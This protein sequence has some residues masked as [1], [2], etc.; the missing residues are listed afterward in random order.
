VERTSATPVGTVI[1][2]LGKEASVRT[3]GG[4]GPRVLSCYLRGRLFESSDASRSQIVVGDRVEL[5]EVGEGRGVIHR[6]LPR[7]RALVRLAPGKK[8]KLHVLAANVDQVLIV[9]ALADPPYKLGL[10]DRYLVI[11]HQAGIA[12]ALCLNKIDLSEGNALERASA[13][14]SL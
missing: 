6:V 3:E 8:P 9:S 5:D 7:E 14:L 4:E 11:A 13:D 10:I 12:P 2:I 1:R